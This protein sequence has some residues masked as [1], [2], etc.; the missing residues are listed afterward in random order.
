MARKP[1]ESPTDNAATATAEK[2]KRRPKQQHIPGMEPPTIREIE[3]AAETY[4]TYRDARMRAGESEQQAAAN[5]LSLMHKNNLTEYEY[6]G[7]KVLI[8]QLEKVKVKKAKAAEGNGDDA[9]E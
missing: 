6:E 4:V 2:P 5:L 9:E 1:K 7:R 3:D 8:A